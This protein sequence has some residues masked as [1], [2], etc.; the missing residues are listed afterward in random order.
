MS[1]CAFIFSD[2]EPL[3]DLEAHSV[4]HEAHSVEQQL[5]LLWHTPDSGGG[6]MLVD[7]MNK[8]VSHMDSDW[9]WIATK[10]WTSFLDLL[11]L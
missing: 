4:K 3:L 9:R 10:G 2:A 7:R 11:G 8:R 5:Q 6:Q 1:G